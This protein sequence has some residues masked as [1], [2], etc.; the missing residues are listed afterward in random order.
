MATRLD[1][2]GLSY[3]WD[4][5]KAKFATKEVATTSEAGLMSASDK[6][7][8]DGIAAGAQVN[9]LTGVKGNAESS[10]RQG[11]VNLTPANI[12]AVSTGLTIIA[13][14][15]DNTLQGGEGQ[16]HFYATNGTT[17]NTPYKQGL[18]EAAQS[19]L[20]VYGSSNFTTQIC[21]GVADNI[22]YIRSKGGTGSTWNGRAWT[23]NVTG[24]KGNTES[25]YRQG[26]VNITPEN[27]GSVAYSTLPVD[28]NNALGNTIQAGYNAYTNSPSQ[29]GAFAIS[30]P[31]GEMA[32][33]Q[34]WIG[35]GFTE[36][37]MRAYNG[38]SWIPWGKIATE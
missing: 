19:V 37:Y 29:N 14:C 11:N 18:T 12:G 26:N 33:L 20:F 10:Y 21:Y 6:A 9:S 25:S 13:D 27:I 3:L 24:I 7:K 32:K 35:Y 15:D 38:L 16:I 2:S 30:I 31:L 1:L 28:L 5:I 34:F 8:L 17:L 4:K 23:A 36:I 22:S